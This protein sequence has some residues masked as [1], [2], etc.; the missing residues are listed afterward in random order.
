LRSMGEAY[1]EAQFVSA[2]KA[3]LRQAQYT[4]TRRFKVK[5]QAG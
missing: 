1:E 5:K 2:E 4:R 3:C